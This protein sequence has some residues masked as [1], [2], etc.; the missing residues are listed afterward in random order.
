MS[1]SPHHVHGLAADE[2]APDWPPLTMEEV[3]GLLRHYPALTAPTEVLWRSPRPLSAGAIIRSGQARFFVKRHHPDVRSLAD[4]AEEHGFIRHL[5]AAG[6]AIPRLVENRMGLTATTDGG[7]NY[8]LSELASGQDLY[9]DSP[10]WTPPRLP[11]HARSAGRALASLHLAAGN[12][13]APQRKTWLL[14][15]RGELIASSNPVDWLQS[16]LP[17]RPGLQ[18]YLRQRPWQSQIEALF[19]NR[20]VDLPSRLAASPPLWTHNDWH[21]SN[22]TWQPEGGQATVCNVLDFGLSARTTAIH[23]LATAIERNAVAWL[24]LERGMEAVHVDIALQLLAGYN[25]IRPLTRH[26]LALLHDVLPLVHV[27]FALSEVEYFQAITR[28]TADADVAWDTFLLGHAQ[29]FGTPPGQ[30][31]LAALLEGR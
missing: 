30:R 29:W 22:L 5:Q 13:L 11:A 19:A 14:L 18:D 25:E 23:D 31:L 15:D 21:V 17:Q 9:R 7:W 6:I 28:S 3:Q 26:D 2:V 20:P 24:E 10:S 4:L 12:Y 27:D 16:Q 8:E 1:L